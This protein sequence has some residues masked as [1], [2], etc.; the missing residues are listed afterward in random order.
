MTTREII[1][2]A[3]IAS[4]MNWHGPSAYSQRMM[5]R[6]QTIVDEVEKR[7]KSVEREACARMCEGWNTAMTDKLASD[8]R[9]MGD[10]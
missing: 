2:E 6:I 1:S 7:A 8:I 9:A 4:L 10:S 3:E 5:E